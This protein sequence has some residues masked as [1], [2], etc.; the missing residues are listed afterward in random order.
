MSLVVG[1]WSAVRCW[2]GSLE[3][4]IV[5]IVPP[6]PSTPPDPPSPW[7]AL[8]SWGHSLH[9]LHPLHPLP[10]FPSPPLIGTALVALPAEMPAWTRQH[11]ANYIIL[12]LVLVL[13]GATIY[14]RVPARRIRTLLLLQCVFLTLWCVVRLLKLSAP[15]WAHEMLWMQYYVPILASPTIALLIAQT[16]LGGDSPNRVSRWMG[17]ACIAVS[18]ALLLL[19]ET[20]PVHGQ[21]F[22]LSPT[23][24]DDGGYAYRWGYVAV[25]AWVALLLTCAWVILV[26]VAHRCGRRAI[27]AGQ[28][29]LVVVL[30]G[31]IVIY[32]TIGP[33]IR[34]LEV[35][36]VGI[37]I[38]VALWEL[39]LR[40]GQV[41]TMRD[42]RRSFGRSQVPARLTSTRGRVLAQTSTYRPLVR[43]R[44]PSTG[45]RCQERS[46]VV[47]GGELTW[48][49]DVEHSL[50]LRENLLR[51][52]AQA[53]A[54]Y[55]ALTRT[56]DLESLHGE[57]AQRTAVL[58]ALRR[59]MTPS[60]EGVARV[61]ELLPTASAPLRARL[62]RQACVEL[63]YAKQAGHLVLGA[64]TLDAGALASDALADALSR[65]CADFSSSSHAAGL[66]RLQ[67]G[68]ASRTGPG[69]M[70]L[71]EVLH[72]LATAHAV[73]LMLAEVDGADVLMQ[74]DQTGDGT[75]LRIQAEADGGDGQGLTPS[76][77][78]RLSTTAGRRAGC[79]A[80]V[81][82]G[83]M[84]FTA[85]A[86][87]APC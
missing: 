50:Q 21:V 74:L 24:I 26:R 71:T 14:W 61:G 47:P 58:D 70:G 3:L 48:T 69:R 4:P 67:G 86:Q 35:S 68:A 75:I 76:V 52:R 60:L 45:H 13:W 16:M 49:V 34:G 1:A 19:V 30:A 53:A 73:L 79:R 82:D 39:A 17:R 55:D 77:L 32:V 81:E 6:A 10:S 85:C 22:A 80:E 37:L 83:V 38:I 15:A 8:S 43:G 33:L 5:P 72:L 42:Y 27:M 57:L 28:I 84:R 11:M 36:R 63:G 62:L 2:A 87:G 64:D 23:F 40:S 44:D 31:Y 41:P 51:I 25:M 29:G 20:N 7:S 54:Q 46:L 12:T 18:A 78:Q 56:A 9:S 65:L 66:V 59:V